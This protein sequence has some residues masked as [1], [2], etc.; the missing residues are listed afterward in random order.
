VSSGCHAS[1]GFFAFFA[2]TGL[3]RDHY[4][5]SVRCMGKPAAQTMAL[6][7]PVDFPSG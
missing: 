7:V 2:M 6:D 4:S 3:L 1:R 5:L